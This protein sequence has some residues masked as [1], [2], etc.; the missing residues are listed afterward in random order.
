MPSQSPETDEGRTY[1][2]AEF[3]VN[4]HSRDVLIDPSGAVVEVEEEVAVISPPPSVRTAI[5]R[6]AGQGKLLGVESIS[7]DGSIIAYEARIKNG[8]K[9]T[10]VKFSPDGTPMK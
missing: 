4:G 8:S 1:F 10:E 2:E 7:K 3:K 5:E 6:R 9:T